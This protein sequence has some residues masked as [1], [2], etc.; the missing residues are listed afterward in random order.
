M[1]HARR[2]VARLG[3]GAA[4]DS[5]AAAPTDG[6]SVLLFDRHVEKNGGGSLRLSM[7]DSNCTFHGQ[8]ATKSTFL[9]IAHHL[10]HNDSTCVEAHSPVADDWLDRIAKISCSN[11][12][13]L[14]AL[15]I[16]RPDD[17]YRSFYAWGGP[18]WVNFS[19]WFPGN[20]QTAILRHSYSAVVAQRNQT[21][22][23]VGEAECDAV[24]RMV[25]RVDFL[26]ATEESDCFLP[27]LRRRTGLHLPKKH[28]H[29]PPKPQSRH[30]R[31]HL[32]PASQI[33]RLSEEHAWCD[34][35]LYRV[36]L[37]RDV[38]GRKRSLGTQA[39]VGQP[40]SGRWVPKFAV[41][42]S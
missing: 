2:V 6:T 7:H 39:V 20:L 38:C 35:V 36:A 37:E 24:A 12:K 10:Q 14:T 27:E 25:R 1:D 15:R 40:R 32:P 8:G 3:V 30:N 26:Y 11:C 13:K 33:L 5:G 16:R 31:H 29:E 18:S 23:S 22:P 19:D 9:R 17:H 28:W 41:E 4:Y 34:W 42:S 21:I